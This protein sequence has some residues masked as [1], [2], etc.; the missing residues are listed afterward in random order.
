MASGRCAALTGRTHGCTDQ[1]ANVKKTLA[2]SE[3]STH[4]TSL[5]LAPGTADRR[6]TEQRR[7]NRRA[8]PFGLSEGR[9]PER[10]RPELLFAVLH[11]DEC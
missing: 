4:G 3:P 8:A 6:I 5:P 1:P 10:E 9:P 11:D 2:N 7:H